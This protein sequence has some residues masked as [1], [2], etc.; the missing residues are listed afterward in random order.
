M[1]RIISFVLS[2]F[3]FCSAF[4][5][6]PSAEPNLIVGDTNK[7][8]RINSIDA[9]TTLSHAVSKIALDFD[10][11]HLSDIN[12]DG[13]ASST[14]ALL[15][16]QRSV[17]KITE[18]TNAQSIVN[19]AYNL[20]EA[21]LENNAYKDDLKADTSFVIDNTGLQP[22]TIYYV[23]FSVSPSIHFRRMMY[24]LQ[25]II[26]RDFGRN[27]NHTSLIYFYYD[28]SDPTWYNYITKDG[29][30][31]EDFNKV[32]I[33]T[34][35]EF[36]NTF[37]NQILQCG[38]ILWDPNVPATCNVALTIC[39]VDGYLP[40]QAG[41]DAET[42]LKN[43]GA[44]EKMSLV[45]MFKNNASTL[46]GSTTASSKSAKN[47]A[48]L[49]ALEKYFDRCSASYL[50]Y[51]VDGCTDVEGSPY[52]QLWNTSRRCY[53]NYDYIVARRAF[54]FDLYPYNK[55]AAC[56][57]PNQKVGTDHQTL[58]KIFTRRY[59]RANGEF[60]QL[61]GFPPWWLKYCTDT[62]LPDGTPTGSKPATWIE[63]LFS[64]IIS[65]FNLAKE[66]DAAGLCSM[67]NGSVYY[68][69]RIN[70]D[71]EFKNNRP[72]PMTYDPDVH[73]FTIYMGDY[74]S[75]AWLKVL[76]YQ[77]WMANGG[78]KARGTLP[79][80]WAYNA[81][82]SYRVPMVF[83]YVYENKTANDYFV[84]G[85]SGAGYV[86]PTGLQN[87]RIL[88]YAYTVR[89]PKYTGGLDKWAEYSRSFYDL[90]D[91]DITGFIIN[92][93]NTLNNGIYSCFNKISPVGSF[94]NDFTQKLTIYNGVPY[95]HLHN[96]IQTSTDSSV[97]YNYSFSEMGSYNFS[98]FRTV[99]I[100]PSNISNIVDKYTSYAATKGKTVKYVDM[101]S[102]F[103]LIR[104]SGQG[105]IINE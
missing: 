87:N 98:G 2:V 21:A 104:Q 73:Y 31:F 99:T 69:Y 60:G 67:S 18:F 11:I 86:I 100:S 25:G 39:G 82:L 95:V 81:N 61:L 7:D 24:A 45:G 66:A 35:T 80:C 58:R 37:K 63:W 8:G 88:N 36:L 71:F 94:H 97:L 47:D 93:N 10:T 34:P 91:Y 64:E 43:L 78:D 85:N 62:V 16:L 5:L 17:G 77:Q 48:Y 29:N 1:K 22:N 19:T 102:I 89:N 65:C 57:D 40:V 30:Y 46:P 50:A 20:E 41:T 103:D 72:D 12:C 56:D 75:S 53:E 23:T 33:S 90:F 92:G 105:K 4:P 27:T 38:Y 15:I 42:L 32:V 84:S 52:S 79:L 83:Q 54:A 14:D 6:I 68:K 70:K 101:Y 59:E 74:D 3:I 55:E 13:K 51:I 49:W 96:G 28:N 44:E 26:N 9:L 76:V